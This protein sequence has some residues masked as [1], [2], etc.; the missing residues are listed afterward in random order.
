MEELIQKKDVRK[1]HLETKQ[2]KIMFASLTEGLK[3]LPWDCVPFIFQFKAA[4]VF[5][6]YD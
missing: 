5:P 6:I 4:I 2:L 1:Y 3:T